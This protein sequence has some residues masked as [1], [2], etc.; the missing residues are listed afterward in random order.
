MVIST[1]TAILSRADGTPPEKRLL[2]AMHLCAEAGFLDLDLHFGAE[3]RDGFPLAQDGWEAFI[4]E[5][6]EEAARLGIR[7]RQAHAFHYRT[8]ESTAPLPD[9]AWYEERILRSLIAAQKLGVA[10]LVQHPS[11]FDQAPDYDFEKTRAY[12]LAYWAPFVAEAERRRVG[13]AFEN[14]YESGH[15]QRYCST[16]WELTDLI[17]SFASEY[18][19]ACWDTGHAAVAGQDQDAS[20][21][22]LG[23]RLKAM[24]IHDNH[25]R[26]K[27]DEHLP[28][29]AGALDWDVILRA[30]ADVGY[31]GNFSFEV[32]Q[33][34][35]RLPP[36]MT[37]PMLRYLHQL[38]KYMTDR[39]EA[40][41]PDA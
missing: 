27:D 21:R 36:D 26:P 28:P 4:D 31:R 30:V 14:L 9:R 15:H 35:R 8:R 29:Y 7:F 22:A 6:G 17:D 34:M 32:K 20:I 18:V 23:S 10:W 25:L 3:G 16:A 39:L 11:D 24:H 5:I 12:N 13:I 40:F 2:R 33:P 37:L 1:T 19:G 38:G 41:R